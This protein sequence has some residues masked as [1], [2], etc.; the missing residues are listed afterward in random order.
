MQRFEQPGRFCCEPQFHDVCEDGVERT[1]PTVFS[2]EVQHPRG[3]TSTRSNIPE[4]QH[5]RGPTSRRSNIH[6]VQHPRGPTSQ[7]SNFHEVQHPRGPTFT[8]SNIQEVQ[9]P[10]GPKS[11]RSNIQE[12]Q[13]PRGPTSRRSNIQ[14]VQE[15]G[16]GQTSDC[17]LMS[18]FSSHN[19]PS[20]LVATDDKTTTVLLNKELFKCSKEEDTTQA[21]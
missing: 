8:R 12:V 7:R 14:E 16:R 10:G 1:M 6:E 13:H 18:L 5:P 11:R 3:P 15:P 21:P 20:V 17:S 19:N 4:V 2:Q 9:H